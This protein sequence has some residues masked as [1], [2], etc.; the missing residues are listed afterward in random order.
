L[1]GFPVVYKEIFLK[2]GTTISGV[3]LNYIKRKTVQKKMGQSEHPI[4]TLQELETFG[5]FIIMNNIICD[6]V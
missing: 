2:Q 1:F 6:N 4:R 5:I 3:H